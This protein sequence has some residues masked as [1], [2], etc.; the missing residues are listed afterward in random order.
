MS[1]PR[2]I[3]LFSTLLWACAGTA[4][5]RHERT[6]A[7]PEPPARAEAAPV[8]GEATTAAEAAATPEPP[9]PEGPVPPVV[10]IPLEDQERIDAAVEAAIARGEMPG[11]VVIVGRR[12]GVVFR[13]AYGRRALE[14]APLPMEIDTIFDL[15]SVTKAVATATAVAMLVDEG[16]VDLDRPVAA[17][18]PEFAADGKSEVTVRQLLT[19]TGGLPPAN[20]LSDFEDGAQGALE[21]ILAVRPAGPAG[22]Y[23]YSDLGFIV[24]GALV[25]RVSG[26]TLDAFARTRIFEPLGMRESAFRPGAEL[27]PRIAPTE[28]SERRDPEL[29]H[30]EVHDPRAWRLGGVAGNA[31][32][33]STAD[34]LARFA[35]AMLAGGALDGARIVREETLRA[36]TAPERAGRTVRALGWN[37]ERGGAY[38]HG[39]FTGTALWIDP[40]AGAFLVFLSNRVHPDGSGDVRPLVRTLRRMASEAASRAGPP[41]PEGAPVLLGVDALRR[42]GFRR[43]A[44]ARVGLVTNV[45]GRAR[46][47]ARTLDLLHAAPGVTVVA[48]FAPEH[49]LS[50]DREGHV[51]S[52]RDART[53]LPVHS[54][55]GETRRPTAEQLDGVDT[56]VFD[57]QDV[58]VRF[59]TYMSTM[60]RAMEAAAERDL[61]FV[62]LDRPNPLGGERVEGPVL[63]DELRSFVN[64]HALPVRHGMTPG[65]LAR[66]LNEERDV[67]AR[68]EVVEVEG[69][70]RAMYWEDT[71]LAWVPPSPNLREPPQ[72]LL[73]PAVALLEGTNVS[74]GRGTDRPF[75]VVGA[76]WMD[77]EAIVRRLA[78]ERL[79]GVRVEPTAFVPRA[80]PHRRR[81][82]NGVRL[83]VTDRDAYRP[84]R[85]GLALARALRAEHADR[86]DPERLALLVGSRRTADAAVAGEPLDGIAAAW[87]PE[88]ARFRAVRARYLAYEP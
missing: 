8:G 63:E 40:Q 23:Q 66:M 5:H 46:D 81:R 61:R 34:D 88:L 14:P 18:V 59:Y 41:P 37:A 3:A 10:R 2:A 31:G 22:R 17:Y 33:F 72:V 73:Y 71:G 50:A 15:A 58:G 6:P 44:G 11:A 70:R 35:R 29:I 32:L 19:H 38:G 39:G 49:G 64:Y 57:I 47:G 24:L 62:V 21:R 27:R 55:F 84:V 53:D 7:P 79:A 69:W 56:L 83:E 52:G 42:D 74:V 68:L 25:E 78:E 80:G 82:C 16:R 30:G 87:E 12:D 20:P 4:E 85:T 45:S 28:R 65:E 51:R 60:L 36:F 1:L 76:P 13:R 26:Q 67:G 54:L 86:W 9:A 48:V 75:E 77:A 43:L